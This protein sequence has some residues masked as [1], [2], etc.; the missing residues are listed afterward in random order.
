MPPMGIR[1]EIKGKTALIT[2]GARGIGM[3]IALTFARAGADI[4]LLDVEEGILSETAA[5]VEE[6]GRKVLTFTADVTDMNRAQEVIKEI[7]GAWDHLDVLVN[8]AG[9]T[10]DNLVLRMKEADWDAV[11]AVNT[12]GAFNYSKAAARYM[13]KQESGSIINMAS[14]IG[15]MGNAGQVNYSASKAA[16]IGMTKSLARELGARNV[17]VNAIAPGYIVTPMTEA[18]SEDAKDK[19]KTQIPLG[20]LGYPRD[21]ANAALFL[22]SEYSSYITGGVLLVS[23]GMAM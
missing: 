12:K 13:L 18:L 3:E 9:I 19:I 10:R 2:G 11:L 8:N 7:T 17:R 21:V 6:T 22:A 1:M 5:R 15:I 23:G 14:I 4:A 20:R 16:L